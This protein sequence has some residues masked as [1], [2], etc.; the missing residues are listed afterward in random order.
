MTFND[1][2]VSISYYEIILAFKPN[3]DKIKFEKTY[4]RE[5]GFLNKKWPSMTSEV[6]VHLM[7]YLRLYNVI[8]HIIC[9]A[10]ECA[11][12]NLAKYIFVRCCRRIYVLNNVYVHLLLFILFIQSLY[13]I[14]NEISKIFYLILLFLI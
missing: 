4:L 5:R 14:Y 6:T 11:R 7:K 1:P 3:F 13:F 9:I 12:E 8:I 2:S 10:N